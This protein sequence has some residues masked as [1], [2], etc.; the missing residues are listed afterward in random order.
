[1]TVS[2]GEYPALLTR[3]YKDEKFP[4]PR[5]VF[6]L[7]K[8]LPVEEMEKLM[9]TN[10]PATDDDI[11]ALAARRA[12]VVQ[13]W[14]VEQGKVPPERVFLLPPKVEHDDKGKGSRVDFSL[15]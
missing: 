15:R 8:D 5:N 9:L 6:G 11:A 13:G 14:L 12:E 2:P 1:M 7:Q 3:V 4:K 10:L